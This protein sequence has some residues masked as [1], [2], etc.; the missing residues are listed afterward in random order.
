MAYQLLPNLILVLAIIGILVLVLRRLPEAAAL[1]RQ[2]DEIENEPQQRML[3]KGLPARTASRTKAAATIVIQRV[4]HFMLEAKGLR[5][6]PAVNY[7][8]KK[9]WQRKPAE[10]PVQNENYY[11]DQIKQAPKD[12]EAY[13]RLGQYYLEH[14]DYEE[15]KNVYDYLVRHNPS[16]SDYLAKLGYS[17]LFLQDYKAAAEQYK[18]SLKLDS[19][20]PSRYYNLALAHSALNQSKQ[21]ED[22]LKKALAL[23][24]N[25]EKYKKMLDHAVVAQSVEQLHGKE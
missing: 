14:K 13:N 12:L 10:L 7:K 5:Q 23:E 6:T 3:A 11:L 16:S 4:W 19:S 17:Y 22:A 9:I 2:Q 24:P 1:K 25:N 15:A 21:V 8:M 18:K 20:H